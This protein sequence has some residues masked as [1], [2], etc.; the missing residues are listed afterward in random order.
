MGEEAMQMECGEMER[1]QC[2]KKG[3]GG[4]VILSAKEL[5]LGYGKTDI[6]RGVTLTIHRAEIVTIIGPNGSGKSTLLKA[7]AR[8]LPLRSGRIELEGQDIWE[9]PMRQVAQRI[10]FLPQSADLPADITVME[11]VRMGRLPHRGFWDG[12]SQTDAE[13]SESA[14]RQTGLL[15]FAGRPLTALSGG[16]QQR[17]RLAM[18]L[19][20]QPEILLLDEPTTY[21]DICHQLA[22]MELVERLHD[23]LGL[24]VIM[25]L[26]DLNQAM[27]YSSHLVAIADG[28]VM[29][30]GVPEDVFTCDLVR[31]LYG[32]DSLVQD[33]ELAGRRTRLC[34]PQCVAREKREVLYA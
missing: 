21:L 10:A 31:N 26:H 29:A 5:T 28:R 27:R 2:E 1:N 15:S 30:D 12:F 32:V 14:L 6:V 11:L 7:L 20:Q 18:A 25:V 23:T 34:F 9:Q 3:S 16:E 8:I 33:M 22:L 17:V 19:A 4:Q 24:T 13:A